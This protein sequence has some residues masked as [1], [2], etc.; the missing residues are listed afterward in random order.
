MAQ[1]DNIS[2]SFG[3]QGM[4]R[5]N[6]QHLLDEKVFTFQRN[7][8]METD[9]ESIG[10]T[11]EHSN[12]LCSRFK[13]EY[14]VIGHKY[15]S[16]NNRVFFFLTEKKKKLKIKRNV[17]G[18]PILDDNG[19]EI[20]ILDKEGKFQ[21]ARKSE[22][23]SIKFNTDISNI[24]DIEIDC[25]CDFSSQLSEPLENQNQIPHCKYETIISDDCNYC[26]NF[27]PNYPIFDVVLK[28][29]TCGYTMTFTDANNPPRYIILDKLHPYSYTGS[30]ACGN[31]ETEPTCLDCEK[32]RIFPLYEIPCLLPKVIQFGGRL[33]RGKYEFAIAYCDKL[34]NEM[35]PYFSLTYP[36]SIFDK[37]NNVLEQPNLADITNLGIRLE[38]SNLDKRFNYY[39]I[40]VIQNA[41]INGIVSPLI[42]GIHSIT[43]T[44]ILYT[45]DIDKQRTTL[46]HI[47]AEKPNYKT[48]GGLTSANNY[49]IG[50]DYTLEKEWNLQP[51]VN[52]MGSLMRWQTVEAHE[53]LY[54]DGVNDSLYTGY[55]RD[56]VYPFGIRFSTSE[57]YRTSVFPLI[58]RPGTDEE[59]EN[60][61]QS[62]NKDV[63]SIN[64][65]IGDC[66]S[67]DRKYRWQYYNTGSVI[68]SCAVSSG[69]DG[70]EVIKEINE[71][72][73][74]K[75][76]ETIPSGSITLSIN[77]TFT[78]IQNFVQEHNDEICNSN[79]P[80]YNSQLCTYL[81]NQYPNEI[82]PLDWQQNNIF[83]F[84]ICDNNCNI[85]T[86]STPVIV[87][88]EILIGSVINEQIS[89]T[90][91]P[92]NQYNHSQPPTT[93]NEY[94]PYAS[95]D[96]NNTDT[97]ERII[98]ETDCKL[99][100]AYYRNSAMINN[101]TCNEYLP[102]PYND[103]F[104][105]I[106][107]GDTISELVSTIPTNGNGSTFQNYLHKEARWYRYDFTND[108]MI[109]EITQNNSNCNPD[110]LT[111]D[112][113]IRYSIFKECGGTV[114]DSG[115]FNV[116]NGLFKKLNKSDYPLGY[117]YVVLDCP[118]KNIN[119]I[120]ERVNSIPPIC[121]YQKY[122]ITPPCGCINLLVREIE[123]TNVV[124]TY[125]SMI[126]D[127]KMVYKSNCKFL[128][129][130][131][132][133][134]EPV[135]HKYGKFSYWES[136][137]KYPDNEDLYDSS[138]LIISSD[139]LSNLNS[140]LVNEFE[141][142]YVSSEI[143]GKYKWKIKNGKEITNF[144]CEPIRHFK[145]PD[146]RIIPFMDD[147]PISEF[148]DNRI[149]PIGVTIDTDVINTFLDIAVKNGL[150]TQEQRSTITNFELFRGDRSIYKSI[151]MKGI[152]NDMYEDKQQ[153]NANQLTLFRNFP[154]NTLG[155]NAFLCD[156]SNR[157]SLVKHP[158]NSQK[159]NRFSL[160]APEIYYNRP[161]PPTEVSIEG[162]MYG[163][164]MGGFNSVENHSEWVILGEKAYNLAGTLATL[165]VTFE[166]IMNSATAALQ[167]SQTSYSF[168][169]WVGVGQNIAGVIASWIAAG[170]IT[171]ANAAAAVL[172]K[173]T[174]Y[175]TQWLQ[176]FEDLG[177]T[178]NFAEM[179]ISPKGWYNSFIPNTENGNMLR[180]VI[181]SKYLK[182]GVPMFTEGS[183]LNG[184]PIRIN[185]RDRE[186]S[187]YI[188]FGDTY[189][190][191]YPQKYQNYDNYSVAPN[192]SSR[193]LSSEIGCGNQTNNLR[194][195]ASPYFSMKNYIP[196]QYGEI[197]G[198]K[199]LSIN[200][201]GKLNKYEECKNIFGGD[202]KITRVDFKNKVPLFT[203]TAMDIANRIPFDYNR[204]GNMA[205]PR[206]YCSYKSTDKTIGI[207]DVPYISTEF[208]FDCRN[209]S[210][211]FYERPPNK[212][213]LYLYGIPYFLVESEINC[214]YRYAGVE[215]HEQFASNGLNVE[216]WVQEKNTSIA[217]NNIFYYNSIYSK[218]QTGLPYRTL[219]G[220]YDKETWDCLADSPNGVV[221]SQQDNSEISLNDP[222]LV[223]K[224]FD[225]Y[226]FRTD[227]GKLVSMRNIESQQV[228]ARFENNMAIF[229]AVDVLKDRITTENE[230]LGMG[231]MFAQ[232][233]VQF[234]FTEL[235]ETGSQHKTMV[236]CEFGHFWAD[237]K[238]GK[239]FQLQPNGQNLSTISD[240]RGKGDESGMRKWFKRHLPFKILKGNKIKGLKE[241]NIDN[242]F[243]G[244]GLLMWWD[245]RFKRV[246]ITKRDYI[247][248]KNNLIFNGGEFYIEGNTTPIELTNSEYFKDISWTLS[249]S[250]I[251]QNWISYYDFKPDY[252]ISYNDYFQT[253]LNYSSDNSEIG[254][255]SHLLTNKSFQVFYGKK[256]PW[257]I[258]LPIKNN[259]VNNILQ[260]IQ[261]W[262]ISKRYHN[263]YDYAVWRKKGFNKAIVYNQ[264]NNS[265]LLHLD[266]VDNYRKSDYPKLIS[267]TEQLIPVT[268]FDEQIH[269]NYFYNRV[270]KEDSHL[271]I[272]FWDEN[273]INK[274]LNDKMI[275][276]T[277]KKVLERMRG[278]W[279]LAKF[280]QDRDTQFKQ[281]FKWQMSSEQP[282]K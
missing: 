231:G 85:G 6:F 76:V 69:V 52:L 118:I 154:Y 87:D 205:T 150:I 219:T 24:E 101:L 186:D 220:V 37:N 145:F 218:Q 110:I 98:I 174:R 29:E 97:K 280:I 259:Y 55:M 79:S 90:E 256:Y 166:A 18:T 140:D 201:C 93:C 96:Q 261:I 169:G 210:N 238:R 95:T 152:V 281:Y 53:D 269:F 267:Q 282:Y 232:R 278:D 7:G 183:N 16:N 33:K 194:R 233:P 111:G 252:A 248:L 63:L 253:G 273:E 207:L 132:N 88:T 15:D 143:N 200:H 20:P 59:W 237:A 161:I 54:A 170:V 213:Y 60:I 119:L 240:F 188:S 62:N 242:P 187:L 50:Y 265:G 227:Y 25:G 123:Y 100:S 196:N 157:N 117:V 46:N 94:K 175:K 215:P 3:I 142:Y 56:E 57:G 78:S 28:Q 264:T 103:Q 61:S 27:D 133:G 225:I 137:V 130:E 162:Y 260:D 23:G 190:L 121:E 106:K 229:N 221:Y 120:G 258:E 208:N 34:G 104:F 230:E 189:H 171:V 243:K 141:E 211:V 160:I 268:H 47:F 51:V 279:F 158:Y 198:V 35:S 122:V 38:V 199:W 107:I 30:N 179:F 214:N 2:L 223:F 181:A 147:I 115:I 116:S 26:L 224:P 202:I 163:N 42:E 271:P 262:M 274:T 32:L 165:E 126:L 14:V 276:F 197:D 131:L 92:L 72:C 184:K 155:D 246:F 138:W 176:T 41:D 167:A 191:E 192:N 257:E 43:D 71:Q 148:S 146:N 109:L 75:N 127:K 226:Q 125:D 144:I 244:I 216:S 5:S 173:Q 12:L 168:I 234:S 70:T 241:D 235:G 65:G 136:E 182:P 31:D 80:Y 91:K 89:F 83:P 222:W 270:R 239:V 112:G 134:C 164:S 159:N 74:I 58:G 180:G 82:C 129:P 254:L 49:L 212:L 113:S 44:V 139:D 151:I 250:P 114:F 255:W 209:N 48:W 1:K 21:Y 86:C 247:P 236:S 263:E 153:S 10:L 177:N 275:S 245:S 272:W 228:L 203:V 67:T 11:N 195:I 77:D 156:N 81:S 4:E 172:F 68:G 19:K 206:F 193:Y 73:I 45:S 99:I 102:L 66:N 84:P 108:S 251:Y 22:I 249:Y 105:N 40:A 13:E 277:S 149:Y 266:Y 17:D 9:E 185:N 178:H 217:F 124:V 64:S 8:N 204:Y 36:I 39:K 128:I 135:P